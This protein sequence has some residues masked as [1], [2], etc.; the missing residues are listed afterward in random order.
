LYYEKWVCEIADV[1]VSFLKADLDESIYIEWPDGVVKFG[2]ESEKGTNQNC[3]LLN[4]AL[5]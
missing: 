2:I 4:E 3:I 1:E 5:Y